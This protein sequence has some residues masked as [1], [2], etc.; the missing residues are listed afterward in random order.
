MIRR[1]GRAAL[2]L[3]GLAGRAKVTSERHLDEPEPVLAANTAR[4]GVT[5][6]VNAVTT[7]GADPT[8]ADDSTNAIQT[9]LNAAEYQGT[10]F[11]P[12]GVYLLS[13]PLTIPPGVR[14]RG[15]H[16]S[17]PAGD[18]PGNGGSVVSA[19]PA[20]EGPALIQLADRALAGHNS[21]SDEHELGDLTIDGSA[22]KSARTADG[23]RATGRVAG[24]H[25]HD[26]Y[27]Y[28]IPNNGISPG[29]GTS[30][31]SSWRLRRVVVFGAGS[32][33]FNIANFTD[34]TFM[35]CE[36]MASEGDGW[37]ID[38][39]SGCV[40]S[41]CRAELNGGHGFHVTGTNVANVVLTGCST[42]SNN[43]SG[44]RA[45]GGGGHGAILLSGC[46]FGRDGR[47]RGFGGGGYA[48]VDIDGTSNRVI[49]EGCHTHVARDDDNAGPY[50]PQYGISVESASYLQVQGGTWRGVS[51]GWQ[52]G[53]G[54]GTV[55][56]ANVDVATGTDSPVEDAEDAAVGTDSPGEG[57]SAAAGAQLGPTQ[58]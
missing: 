47:N 31:P 44:L 52:A 20:F 10:V 46:R 23:I 53:S 36:A 49:I 3:A 48:G 30:S 34:S 6:W 22:I 29:Y 8:G 58:M 45:D 41:S 12:S 7:Y 57:A 4:P 35:N 18:Q 33:G 16:G 37:Y 1:L 21:A 56:R 50:R 2:G 26:V 13:A 40:L 39:T 55:T 15:N 9:A 27:L 17:F 54:N 38:R 42:D 32:A 19:S 43:F 24:A 14:L 25:F 5:D 11:L 51:A 28:N